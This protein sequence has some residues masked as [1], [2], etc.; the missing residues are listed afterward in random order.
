MHYGGRNKGEGF[1]DFSLFLISAYIFKMNIGEIR[2]DADPV[3]SARRV[4]KAG[5][6]VKG[7]AR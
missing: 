6:G 4:D 3:V 7:E 2:P 1:L 5:I